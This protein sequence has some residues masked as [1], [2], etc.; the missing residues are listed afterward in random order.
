MKDYSRADNLYH[1]RCNKKKMTRKDYTE[2]RY[3]YVPRKSGCKR[4]DCCTG[5]VGSYCWTKENQRRMENKLI[6]TI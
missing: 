4:F 5:K 1:K 2:L 3:G 6:K